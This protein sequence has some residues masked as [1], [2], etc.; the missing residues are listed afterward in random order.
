MS[1]L[2]SP[3]TIKDI[4]FKNRIVQ[5][6]MCMYS[7]KDGMVSDWHFVHYG[8]RAIGG[9][10]TI[11]TEATAVSPEGRIS[12]GD[13]GIWSDAHIEGLK[14][15]TGFLKANGS[16]PGIQ[17]A[18]SGRKGSFDVHG[19]DNTLMRTKEEGGWEVIAPSAIPFSDNTLTPKAMTQADIDMLKEQFVSATKRA[20]VAGFQ[21]LEVHSAHGYLFHSFLS[22]ISN[23]REDQYG[24]SIENRARLLLEVVEKVKTVWPNNL[25]LAVRISAT[26]W[27]KTG[28][29]IEDSKWLAQQLEKAGVDL[30]DVSSG[31]TLPNA[32]IPIGPAYQLPLATAIKG[33]VKHMKV[34]TVG[35]ITN[36]AQAETILL[37]DDADFICFARELLRNPYF[38]LQAAQELRADSNIP[39]QYERGFPKK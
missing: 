23:K 10:G 8:T 24:G 38:A 32:T 14:R 1:K 19:S 5:S 3:L 18:H 16:I 30:I 7:A 17:L 12:N 39:K 11:F 27:D 31:G 6:P 29:T 25:P 9:V 37:N 35:M 2:F 21:I 33:V 4:T 36:A 22:P 34:A 28:W 26:D 15:I 13:L 20:V